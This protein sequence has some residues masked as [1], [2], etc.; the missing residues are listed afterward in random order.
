MSFLDFIHAFNHFLGTWG[1]DLLKR[2]FELVLLTFASYM[3]ASEWLHTKSKDLKYLLIGFG[4][5]AIEKLIA[6]L[7]LLGVVFGG[8]AINPYNDY[9]T[10][11]ENFLEITALILISTAFLYPL[12]KKYGISLKNKAIG[13]FL[14]MS[15]VFFL[16]AAIAFDLIP[17]PL[18][19]RRRTILAS[20]EIVKFII[21]WFPI[22]MFIRKNELTVYNKAVAIAFGVYSITPL[23]NT[24]N[25]LLYSNYRADLSVL[26][27]PFPFIAVVL[28]TRVLFLKLVNKATLKEELIDTKKKYIREKSISTMK[29]EFVSTVSH[30][31]RTPLTSI[32]LYLNLLL[33]G[34]FGGLNEKQQEVVQT[35][36]K[37]SSRLNNLINN[38]LKLSRF[39]KNKET[40]SPKQANLH[41]LIASCMYPHLLEEKDLNVTNNIPKDIEVALDHDQFKQVVINLLTNAINHTDAGG[42]IT[43]ASKQTPTETTLSITDTGKGIPPDTLPYVFD[44]FYQAEGHMVRKTGGIGLGLAIV[45]KIVNLHNGK[46]TVQSELGK[47]TTFTITLPQQAQPI[48]QKAA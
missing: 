45:K 36:T 26:A 21:L 12:H 24:F 42:S 31:L 20:M 32:S 7:F 11:I 4:S 47:G 44:K 8:L 33:N 37:E 46:I 28:F 5:L 38:I 13:E 22:V 15:I 10:L 43:F 19:T 3:V 29:D 18:G 40:I 34:K 25:W 2:S 27:H 30:E 23:L 6:S 35:M 14:G 17:L 48:P 1:G 9:I 16:A 41:K 39:E